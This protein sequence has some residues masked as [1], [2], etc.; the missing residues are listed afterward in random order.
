MFHISLIPKQGLGTNPSFHFLSVITII[1]IIIRE[2]FT[3]ALAGGLSL[4]FKWQQVF[5]TLPSILA[6][7]NNSVVW[8]VSTR[9][10]ISNS[11]SS[12]INPL[13]TI[14]IDINVTFHSFFFQFS[15][16]IQVFI[17]L[18]TF[19]QFYFVVSLD[20]K[21]HNFASS[22]FFVWII[23]RSG[24]L[25][26]IRWSVCTL[27]FQMSLCVTPE[28]ADGLLLELERHHVSSSLLDSS[29]YSGRFW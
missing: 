29:Q 7:F 25:A 2:F 6:D 15:R 17:F 11:S 16:K 8:M 22:L 13:V 1:I 26:E 27:K 14:T 23:L 19:F 21:V 4:D 10:F 20:N 9:P 5:R 18:F 24:R 12:F 28:Q 3:S